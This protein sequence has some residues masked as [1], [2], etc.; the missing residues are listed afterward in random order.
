MKSFS[1]WTNLLY[2][3]KEF[4]M[5]KRFS[6]RMMVS[7]PFWAMCS[8]VKLSEILPC[9]QVSLLI[10]LYAPMQQW[11]T[12]GKGQ[13]SAPCEGGRIGGVPLVKSHMMTKTILVQ[14]YITPKYGPMQKVVSL[15]IELNVHHVKSG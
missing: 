9:D 13:R 6:M 12:L 15:S 7:L 14:W 11:V 10:E 8:H 2:K 4:S 3:K 5:R 1:M